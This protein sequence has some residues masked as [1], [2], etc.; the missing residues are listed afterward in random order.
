MVKKHKAHKKHAS[1]KTAKKH[2]ATKAMKKK[3]DKD[4][5]KS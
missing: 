5:K 1:A 2:V 3:T 4:Q